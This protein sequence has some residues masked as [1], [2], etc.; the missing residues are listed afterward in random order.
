M[1]YEKRTKNHF[2][3]FNI[4]SNH[5]NGKSGF[6]RRAE[7]SEAIRYRDELISTFQS[8]TEL[9]NYLENMP[10]LHFE[11][12]C[13]IDPTRQHGSKTYKKYFDRGYDYDTN[14]PT[15]LYRLYCYWCDGFMYIVEYPDP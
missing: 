3:D 10:A 12:G 7:K 9:E 5:V 14:T 1:T 6:C 11:G 2:F 4:G 8:E 13:G 15:V